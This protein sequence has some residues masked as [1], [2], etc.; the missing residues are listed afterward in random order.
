[1]MRKERIAFATH[2]IL[3]GAR[4]QNRGRVVR[5]VER[6]HEKE[7]PKHKQEGFQGRAKGENGEEKSP[8]SDG[9]STKLAG[10]AQRGKGVDGVGPGG[11]AV[12]KGDAECLHNRQRSKCKQCGWS[13]IC[14]H[15]RQRSKCKQCDGA[16][17]CEHNHLRSQCKQCGGSS[18]CEHN[19]RRIQCRQCDGSRCFHIKRGELAKC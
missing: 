2:A 16:N 15:N 13:S 4:R 12:K 1:M 6:K 5:E 11:C 8:L 18:I 7:E 14:E 19:R 17:I 3:V 10:K 9:A